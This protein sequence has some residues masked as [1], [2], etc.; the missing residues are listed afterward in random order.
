MRTWPPDHIVPELQDAIFPLVNADDIIRLG[1]YQMSHVWL[2]TCANALTKAKFAASKELT[3][4]ARKCLVID[5]E[6]KDVKLKLLWLPRHIEDRR[7]VE[8]LEPFG[9]VV[10]IER[11]K[12]RI[13]GM[14]N[15]QTMNREVT[16]SLAEGVSSSQIP[17]LL[18]VLGCQCLVLVPGRPP[19]CLRCNR[20]GHIRRYCQIPRCSQCRRF[21][22]T[23]E[24][25]V[26]TYADRLRQRKFQGKEPLTE[27]LMDVSEVV[28]PT[29]DISSPVHYKEKLTPVQ[30]P[31]EAE[32]R[33]QEPATQGANITVPV[34]MVCSVSSMMR[35][36]SEDFPP[37]TVNTTQEKNLEETTPAKETGQG[38]T[39][40]TSVVYEDSRKDEM[41]GDS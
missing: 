6:T 1:Q 24:E 26:L 16:L 8:A 35:E 27:N 12:W 32:A 10:S 20:V 13:P 34:V 25:C 18:M 5:P 21:G 37:L 14:E 28:E 3:V 11:E 40:T 23:V 19:L 15:L 7:I 29:G 22:N 31:C 36:A 9:K 39:T 4:K 33:H 30:P 38:T 17:Y 2:I 41:P